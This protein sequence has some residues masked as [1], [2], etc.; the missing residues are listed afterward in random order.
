M[1]RAKKQISDK[2]K[3]RKKGFN[4]RFSERSALCFLLITVLMAVGAF[5]IYYVNNDVAA[6][7]AGTPVNSISL[8]YGVAR[9]EILDCNGNPLTNSKIKSLAVIMPTPQ[10]IAALNK[11]F[12]GDKLQDILERLKSK[13]PIL[14]ETDEL[15]DDSGIYGFYASD[16]YSDQTLARHLIGYLDYT[17]KGISGAEKAFDSILYSNTERKI[18]FSVTAGGDV[19]N[20]IEPEFSGG[21]NRNSVYLTIDSR[22]QQAAEM[23]MK[24]IPV[25]A[26]V[27][28]EV[29]TGKIRAMVSRPNYDQNDVAS[30]LK[31]AD[32]PLLNRALLEY[33]V[34]SVFKPCIAAAALESGLGGFKY[35]CKGSCDIDGH[36]F[37]CHKLSG[38]GEMT[39]QTALEQSC[40]TYFYNL[41]QQ[42]SPELLINTAAS[43]G[44]GGEINLGGGIYAKS[45]NLSSVDE[46][47]SSKRVVAN[48]AIGQGSLL[49]SPVALLNL[50]NAIAMDGSYYLPSIIEKT[51][52]NG[53][54]GNITEPVKVEA[55]PPQNAQL[56]KSYLGGVINNGTGKSAKPDSLGAAGKTATA[57]T[58]WMVD[59]KNVL[60]AWFCGIFPY[61]QPKYSVV[62]FAEN[63]SSGGGDCAPVFK[64]FADEINKMQIT[65]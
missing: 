41:A 50:Y 28:S 5:R 54:A 8:S 11:Y 12:S 53:V 31:A 7:T 9:G 17:G 56:L 34:G 30:S 46:L 52:E 26:M 6:R 58:G 39:L 33:N 64:K 59:D 1:R 18:S 61:E 40:N 60:H 4:V 44:F 23:A 51:T 48:F 57:E 47:K 14:V 35:V 42:I 24:D 38:H 10:A 37:N 43:F 22:I 27:V 3:N 25:G 65:T 45:G 32:S 55:L 2:E 20:G 62:I 36:T 13:K 49:L 63:A 15:I 16:R 19:I 21:E 29:S